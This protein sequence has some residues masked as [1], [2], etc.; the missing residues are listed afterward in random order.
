MQSLPVGKRNGVGDRKHFCF[1]CAVS[2]NAVKELVGGCGAD[3]SALPTIQQS[4]ECSEQPSIWVHA[5]KWIRDD[6]AVRRLFS[7]HVK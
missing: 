1:N 4:N 6:D 3:I 2:E 7:T 5:V